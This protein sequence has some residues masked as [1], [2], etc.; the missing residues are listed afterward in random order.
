MSFEEEKN[1]THTLNTSNI[2]WKQPPKNPFKIAWSKLKSILT[3]DPISI[4]VNSEPESHIIWKTSNVFWE[5]DWFKLRYEFEH[6]QSP[7]KELPLRNF[8]KCFL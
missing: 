1:L 4:G 2:V 5:F 8:L 3:R 6:W 7:W